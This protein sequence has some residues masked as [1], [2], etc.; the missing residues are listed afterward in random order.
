MYLLHRQNVTKRDLISQIGMKLRD[1]I[2]QS[3]V[4]WRITNTADQ[5]EMERSCLAVFPRQI[6]GAI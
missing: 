2:T 5:H 1:A 4:K 6:R 3:D